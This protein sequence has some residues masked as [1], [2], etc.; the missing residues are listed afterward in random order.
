MSKKHFSSAIKAATALAGLSSS[1]EENHLLTSADCIGKANPEKGV[2]NMA[3][4]DD[5]EDGNLGI[6]MTFP[7]IVSNFHYFLQL[8]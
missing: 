2:A 5:E 1:L 4:N 7:Q 3:G 8:L 6:P